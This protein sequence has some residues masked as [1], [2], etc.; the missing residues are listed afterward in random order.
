MI[1]K[2]MNLTVKHDDNGSFSDYSHKMGAYGRDAITLTITSAEDD[3]YVGFA[4]PINAMYVDITSAAGSESTMTLEYWDGS[5][6][7]S[8][9][10]L[11]DDT[12]GMNRSGFIR[13]NREENLTDYA[14]N[15]V[16]GQT[17]YWYKL[18]PGA[19]RTDIVLSGLNLVFSDDYE[20]SLEQPYISDSEFLGNESSHI[21]THVA[22][23]NEIIQKFRNKNYVKI[24][25]ISGDPED[26]TPWDLLDIDEVRLAAS[27][28]ALSKIYYQLSDNP[29]DVWAI[30]SVEYYNKFEKYVNVARLSVDT[31]DDGI[32][33]DVEN[34]RPYKNRHFSR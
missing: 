7:T 4:K 18:N 25:P 22:A 10:E 26:I 15:A 34:K 30:K 33:D 20:L 23:R 6:W 16:D 8:V 14:K 12:M 28:L 9:S 1:D 13:W 32:Q 29:E 19:D 5:A 17:M 2:R 27:Y 3:V 21:K 31:N 24:D 11:S